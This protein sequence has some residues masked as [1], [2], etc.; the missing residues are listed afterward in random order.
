MLPIVSPPLPTMR[1]TIL[2]GTCITSSGSSS[3]SD[4]TNLRALPLPCT[5][6]VA[7]VFS[8]AAFASAARSFLAFFASSWAAAQ[9]AGGE[10]PAAAGGA[11]G[12]RRSPQAAWRGRFWACE[13]S[14]RHP[15]V[16]PWVWDPPG[17]P[18][19]RQIPRF[20]G[21]ARPPIPPSAHGNESTPSP[22][23]R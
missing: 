15:T 16:P 18:R 5:R 17:R 7:A 4:S 9:G 13:A 6:R 12:S 8:A 2:V 10:A 1:R 21:W 23:A 11:S 22:R 20:R 3:L 14:G 19:R